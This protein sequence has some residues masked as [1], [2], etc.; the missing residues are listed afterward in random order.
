MKKGLYAILAVLAVFALVMTGCPNTDSPGGGGTTETK[1]KVTFD[2]NYTGAAA[3]TVVEVVDGQK[4]DST[5]IP[6][7]DR[8]AEYLAIGSW[9]TAADGTGT[10]FDA[11]AVVTADAKYYA[12]WVFS[13]DITYNAN[14]GVGGTKIVQ[15]GTDAITISTVG[16]QGFSKAGWIFD[17]WNTK[18]DGTGTTSYNPGQN[19]AFTEPAVLYAIWKQ[20]TAIAT[21]DEVIEE[22]SLGNSWFALYKFTLPSG[23]TYAD[24]KNGGLVASYKLDA[25]TIENGMLRAVRVM[26]NFTDD[27]VN[28]TAYTYADTQAEDA[29]GATLAA[30]GPLVDVYNGIGMAAVAQWQSGQSAPYIIT[31]MGGAWEDGNVIKVLSGLG[32]T[33]EDVV[34]NEWFTLSYSIDGSQKNGGH[35][36]AKRLPADNATGPFYF[37]VGLPGQNSP[38]TFQVKNVILVGTGGAA[39]VVGMPLY[40]ENSNTTASPTETVTQYRAYSGQYTKDGGNGTSLAGWKIIANPTTASNKIVPI[41]KDLGPKPE[42]VTVT[43][44]YNYPDDVTDVDQPDDKLFKVV[45]GETLAGSQLSKPELDGYFC[46]GWFDAATGGDAINP[47][48]T[49]NTETPP[50]DISTKFVADITIY[51]QWLDFTPN[52]IPWVITNPTMSIQ[53]SSAT[54]G[55]DGFITMG[56][57]AL[58]SFSLAADALSAIAGYPASAPVGISGFNKIKVEYEAVNNDTAG[59]TMSVIVKK[60]FNEWSNT[61]PADTVPNQ[62]PDVNESGFFEWNISAFSDAAAPGFSLQQNTGGHSG[63]YKIKITKITFSFE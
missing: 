46:T 14:G 20:P 43:F 45:K 41:S 36:S 18:A 16:A 24:Y 19:V 37:A 38:N 13:V 34:A 35:D 59:G 52:T 7:A 61:A 33:A 54:Q 49:K 55:T 4:V 27:E 12:Q 5:K 44:D 10:A 28:G 6:D 25:D 62:Y 9:T 63:N 22:L 40:Y 51:A 23:K 31:H 2:L 42:I 3:P 56:G 60:G 57:N 1:W 21:A 30:A 32:L 58:I 50:E 48:G 17:K 29:N 15:A 53:G 47:A 26:G 8:S 39:D 11:N